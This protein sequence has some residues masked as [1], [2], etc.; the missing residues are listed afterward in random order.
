MQRRKARRLLLKTLFQQD[1]R[2]TDPDAL[3]QDYGIEDR[4]V[5]GVLTGIEQHKNELDDIIRRHAQGWTLDRLVSVDRNILRL[6][7]YELLHTDTPP[8]VIINEAVELAKEFGTEQ[9]SAFVNGILDTIWK[10]L[11][12][13]EA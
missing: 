7:L 13:T 5:C 4:F 6:G 3:I 12:P 1:F 8:E 2:Q 9:S 11:H 10:E